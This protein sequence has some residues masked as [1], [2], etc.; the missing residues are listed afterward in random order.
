MF[1]VYY[2]QPESNMSA[3]HMKGI[4]IQLIDEDMG[5]PVSDDCLI[6]SNSPHISR[7]V[8]LYVRGHH[9]LC[10]NIYAIFKLIQ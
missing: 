9:I 4:S 5:V 10:H 1:H 7:Y 6:K 8:F 2:G 3:Q